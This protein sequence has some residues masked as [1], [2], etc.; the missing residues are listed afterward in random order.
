MQFVL[1]NTKV[2]VRSEHYVNGVPINLEDIKE[3]EKE[4]HLKM[5][6]EP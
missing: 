3:D 4:V 2:R 5:Y 6:L 1:H